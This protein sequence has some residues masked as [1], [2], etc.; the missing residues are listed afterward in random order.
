MAYQDIVLGGGYSKMCYE[1]G[2]GDW[3]FALLIVLRNGC[4]HSKNCR[5]K[6]LTTMKL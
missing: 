4:G 3:H 5:Y 1:G 6:E 2:Y